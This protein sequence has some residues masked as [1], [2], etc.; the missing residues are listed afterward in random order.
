MKTFVQVFAHAF[1]WIGSLVART[2]PPPTHPRRG[3]QSESDSR[4]IS[5]RCGSAFRPLSRVC[6]RSSMFDC[7]RCIS[8]S[9]DAREFH[10]SCIRDCVLCIFPFPV[11]LDARPRRACVVVDWRRQR[12]ELLGHFEDILWRRRVAHTVRCNSRSEYMPASPCGVWRRVWCEGV[13]DTS[14]PSTYI[15]SVCAL[16]TTGD[17]KR[18]EL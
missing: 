7:V 8:R 2:P 12:A 6:D 18:E 13:G 3:A 14:K 10:A 16:S 15:I 11:P 1:W 17:Y 5:I 9:L 4:L